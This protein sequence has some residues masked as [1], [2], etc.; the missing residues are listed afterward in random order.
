MFQSQSSRLNC[1]G[2][3]LMIIPPL[4]GKSKN[5]SFPAL[6]FSSS[7]EQRKMRFTSSTT[8]SLLSVFAISILL[9]QVGADW[10]PKSQ[11]S[12]PS[13]L[14]HLTS[15]THGIGTAV[16]PP[17]LV[18]TPGLSSEEQSTLSKPITDVSDRGSRNGF[19]RKVYS[20]FIAQMITT[21]AITAT[22]MRNSNLAYFL[23]AN[24]AIVSL[25]AF[26]VSTA[27][28]LLLCSRPNLRY[29]SP[30]NFILLGIHT[31]CQ[32]VMVGT[33]SS[34]FNPALVC[35]GTMHTLSTF[36]MITAL[37]LQTTYDFTILGNILFT[38]LASLFVGTI[39]SSYLKMPLLDNLLSGA[40]AVLLSCYIAHDTQKIAG[41]THRK[42]SYGRKEYILAAL[43][44]YQDAIA[45][46]VRIMNIISKSKSKRD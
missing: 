17:S 33:F 30:N 7:Q 20:I 27:A 14:V 22:I 11:L 36:L 42:Y 23:Q 37:A 4:Q 9:I 19:V 25:V 46:F 28:V 34:L 6:L 29:E 12:K 16:P 41:G 39:L 1:L 26:V 18:R 40:G 31:L 21:I 35:M 15:S 44:I 32:S 10:T 3:T 43:N 13:G 5:N 38:S 24:F 45:L 2:P 8:S